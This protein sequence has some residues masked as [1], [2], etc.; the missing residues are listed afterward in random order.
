MAYNSVQIALYGLLGATVADQLGGPW[1]AWALT[2]WALVA[3]IGVRGLTL[4]A[5]VIAAV[6]TVELGMIALFDLVAFTHPAHS[7]LGAWVAPWRPD[8]LAT[9]GVGGV[10]ALGVAAFLGF[11]T[12]AAF[13][14]E[15]RT[16][17]SVTRATMSSLGFL[18]TFYAISAWALV[19]AVG[20]DHIAATAADPGS[21]IPFSILATDLGE[22]TGPIAAAAGVVLL[23]GSIL[24]A[25][26]AFHQV[27]ARYLYA[28]GREHVLPAALA[29]ISTPRAAPRRDRP[30]RPR[31]APAGSRDTAGGARR[32]GVPIAGS[33]TQSALALAV[34]ALAALS[35]ADPIATV[36][37][38]LATLSALGL[39]T[40]MTAT[41]LGVIRFYQSTG[42]H[43]GRPTLAAIA[44]PAAWSR[45]PGHHTA[46]APPGPNRPPWWM[47]AGAPGLGALV[48]A[49]ALTVT[50]ASLSGITAVLLSALIV[51]TA[52]V[53]AWRARWL[54]RNHRA[55]YALLGNGQP[56]PLAVRD[57]AVADLPL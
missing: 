47:R 3:L 13:G 23:I 21:G 17:R 46:A 30:D 14:E 12:S 25:M 20:P 15:A 36:F 18:G 8:L 52:A 9:G 2:A 4:G 26:L 39:L 50:V 31:Q 22:V 35:G 44:T 28:L 10:L 42:G 57:P 41:C 48:L 56:P 32:S 1:W 24:S 7:D 49:A 11:E 19:V 34:I 33:I 5:P 55:A 43:R 16:H 37:T 40:L 45:P 53:G 27:V 51:A 6:L 38:G 54:R 29:V